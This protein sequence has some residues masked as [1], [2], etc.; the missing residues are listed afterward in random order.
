MKSNGDKFSGVLNIYKDSKMTSHDVVSI[1]RKIFN[2]QKVGHAGTLDPNAIGVLPIC[3]GK[4]TRIS[5]YLME[6]P[7]TYV[8]EMVFGIKT[9]TADKWGKVIEHKEVDV[10]FEKIKSV[11]KGFFGKEIAQVPPMY[12]ALKYKGRK[13]YEL[14][15]DGITVERKSRKVK[16]YSIK[17]LYIRKKSLIFECTCSKGTYIR[18][19]I[20]DIAEKTGNLA[21]MSMLIRT[22]SG[23]LSIDKSF[24]LEYLKQMKFDELSKILVPIDTALKNLPEIKISDGDFERIVNGVK[25]SVSDCYEDVI[26][27]IYS[28]G[29]FIGLGKPCTVN[30]KRM[31]KMEKVFFGV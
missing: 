13:L 25:V 16:I 24:S 15:R 28:K 26:Y 17:D 2:T 4:A 14:A 21:Y 18:T 1:V 27:K 19:L 10:D 7:K 6:N 5:D 8:A 20:E 12:S 22:S 9:D 31:L 3:I 23:G 11:L 29:K 30:G